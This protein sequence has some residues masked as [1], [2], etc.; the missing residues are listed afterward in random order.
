MPLFI[1]SSLLVGRRAVYSAAGRGTRT[2]PPQGSACS[3]LYNGGPAGRR[4]QNAAAAKDNGTRMNLAR[5][6]RNHKGKALLPV[7]RGRKSNNPCST[8]GGSNAVKTFI[9]RFGAQI[10]GVL[11]GFDRL[12]LRG[13]KR[14][15]CTPGGVFS[16]LAQ[17][18]VPLKD[19]KPMPSRPP[20]R[21]ARP[22]RPRPSEPAS[23][24]TST[25]ATRARSRPRC[26]WR[27]SAGASGA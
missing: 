5:Q 16:F 26:A 7:G 2:F 19:Y 10:L 22:S 6:S 23:T 8:D 9:Q 1:D 15:L 21:C 14:L 11:H 4:E 24:S 20:W 12:R 18:P 17:G 25:T 3:R 27:P 13:S